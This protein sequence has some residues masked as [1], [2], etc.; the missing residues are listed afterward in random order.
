MNCLVSTHLHMPA[1]DNQQ[2]AWCCVWGKY[3]D[4]SNLRYRCLAMDVQWVDSWSWLCESVNE[5]AVL[6][7]QG[8]EKVPDQLNTRLRPTFSPGWLMQRKKDPP[9]RLRRLLSAAMFTGEVYRALSC[10]RLRS[11]L[12]HSGTDLE[13]VTDSVYRCNVVDTR[14]VSMKRVAEP[15]SQSRSIR[16]FIGR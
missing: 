11:T 15:R 2:S 8:K 16:C 12:W 6:E 5:C 9:L 1:L 4:R 14:Q 7:G 10:P 13:H 3:H